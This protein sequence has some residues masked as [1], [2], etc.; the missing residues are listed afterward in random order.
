M[1]NYSI[2]ALVQTHILFVAA[3]RNLSKVKQEKDPQCN[4]DMLVPDP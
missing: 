1:I 3:E 2:T 4:K